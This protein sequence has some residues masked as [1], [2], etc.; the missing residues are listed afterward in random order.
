MFE[1]AGSDDAACRDTWSESKSLGCA[2]FGS[3]FSL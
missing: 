3:T 2:E 1:V